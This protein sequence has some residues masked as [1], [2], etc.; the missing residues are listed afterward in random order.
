MTGGVVVARAHAKIN[1][2]LRVLG[3]RRDGYHELWTVFQTL[4]LHDTL[5]CV[6]CEGPFRIE[7]DAAGVPLDESNLV[8]RAADALWRAAGRR[9]AP[10]GAV[11]HL[12]KR[13]PAQ[14]GLGGGSSDAAAALVALDTLWGCSLPTNALP[15]LAASIGADVPF[16]LAG[17]TA[18]GTGRG[19]VICPVPAAP[20]HGVV[21]L[22]PSFGVSTREAFGWWDERHPKAVAESGA[23][24]RT[25][26]PDRSAPMPVVNDLEDAVAARHPEL[27]RMT[28][29][30]REEGATTAAMTGTEGWHTAMTLTLPPRT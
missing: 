10:S 27:V 16:F 14:G 6:G 3:R 5:A 20:H 24:A 15:S 23:D 30:L 2:A 9:G 25:E 12:R 8:W 13:I 11:V 28:T 21:L 7:C 19:D 17:G 18:V 1:L 22:M 29:A 26:W 4:A